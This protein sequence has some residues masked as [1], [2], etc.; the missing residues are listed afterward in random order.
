MCINE[1]SLN[2]K[3]FNKVLANIEVLKND[4]RSWSLEPH[5]SLD[6]E[7]VLAV[8]AWFDRQI[9]IYEYILELI[10]DKSNKKDANI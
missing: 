6:I 5:P 7:E 8:H 9:E 3:A 1:R 2:A 10:K 4:K